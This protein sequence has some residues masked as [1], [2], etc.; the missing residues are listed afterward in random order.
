MTR[1]VR[2]DPLLDLVPATLNDMSGSNVVDVEEYL[3]SLPIP[4]L[5]SGIAGVVNDCPNGGLGPSPLTAPTM[6]VTLGIVGAWRWNAV[7]I[8][9]FRNG[10]PA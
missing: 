1:L 4:E 5:V 6:A 3:A 2:A 9:A 7:S 8:E 10:V